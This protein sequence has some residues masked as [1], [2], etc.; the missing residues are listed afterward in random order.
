MTDRPWHF[1][2]LPLSMSKGHVA[3]ALEAMTKLTAQAHG[4]EVLIT[5]DTMTVKKLLKRQGGRWNKSFTGWTFQGS[6]KD[7]VV[8]ALRSAGHDVKDDTI[9]RNHRKHHQKITK[10]DTGSSAAAGSDEPWSRPLTPGEPS[11]GTRKRISVSEF[12]GGV[13]VDIREWYGDAIDPKP[14]KKGLALK[15]EEWNMLKQ[16]MPEID[17]ELKRLQDS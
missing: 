4:K 10:D 15:A 6:K 5:G 7:A 11:G 17:A 12:N 13:I 9:G 1:H 14:G 8:G 3:D 2:P 16:A